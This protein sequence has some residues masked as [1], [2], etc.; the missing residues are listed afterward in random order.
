MFQHD[1][2]QPP[3][4]WRCMRQWR[5]HVAGSRRL[6]ASGERWSWRLPSWRQRVGELPLRHGLHRWLRVHA[7]WEQDQVNPSLTFIP[8]SL[9][10]HAPDQ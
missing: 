5:A 2:H 6:F 10:K 8:P 1:D 3:A 9:I 4:L 7:A